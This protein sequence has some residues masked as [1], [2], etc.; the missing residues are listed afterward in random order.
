[1]STEDKIRELQGE[2]SRLRAALLTLLKRTVPGKDRFFEEISKEEFDALGGLRDLLMEDEERFQSSV[3]VLALSGHERWPADAEYAQLF[4]KLSA[5]Q[6]IAFLENSDPL[7]DVEDAK[8]EL[9]E[10]IHPVSKVKVLETP[11]IDTK[12]ADL[13]QSA[14]LHNVE[15]I[16]LEILKPFLGAQMKPEH[17]TNMLAK[18]LGVLRVV[19]DKNQLSP[20][21]WDVE[22][23]PLHDETISV[24]LI[25]KTLKGI[26][27]DLELVEEPDKW[28]ATAHLGGEEPI[29]VMGASGMEALVGLARLIEARTPSFIRAINEGQDVGPS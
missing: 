21:F 14:D 28:K 25:P 17:Y 13:V 19:S 1:M 7:M 6:R 9:R 20:D 18:T 10:M 11:I 2:V 23:V 4:E 15:D 27:C 24:R 12:E 16:I 22:I 29:H 5:E 3:H 26:E 8:K